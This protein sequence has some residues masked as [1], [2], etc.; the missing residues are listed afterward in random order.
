MQRYFLRKLFANPKKL[1]INR[2]GEE[3]EREKVRRMILV[4]NI[5][6]T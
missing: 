6:L 3:I 1:E 4:F 5:S 2:E